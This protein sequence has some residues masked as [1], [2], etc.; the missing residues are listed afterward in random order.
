MIRQSTRS[1][2]AL[3]IFA[4]AAAG[5]IYYLESTRPHRVRDAIDQVAKG[6][7]KATL[8]KGTYLV[9][10]EEA[11][12]V[13]EDWS[14]N[15]VTGKPRTVRLKVRAGE[16]ELPSQD[17]GAFRG[18]KS[19]LGEPLSFEIEYDGETSIEIELSESDVLTEGRRYY[20]KSAWPFATTSFAS[21]SRVHFTWKRIGDLRKSS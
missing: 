18:R 7:D 2:I 3:T 12:L 10:L 5:T 16:H 19:F 9:Q 4:V 15:P 1:I 13:P 20:A 8:A 14:V 21:A 17:L 11:E 6:I